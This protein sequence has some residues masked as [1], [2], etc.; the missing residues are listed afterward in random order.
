VTP[1]AQFSQYFLVKIHDLADPVA[2]RILT[3]DRLAAQDRG[4]N[5]GLVNNRC[6]PAIAA[7]S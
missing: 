7:M 3:R 1:G 4:D 6:L 5:F 2:R